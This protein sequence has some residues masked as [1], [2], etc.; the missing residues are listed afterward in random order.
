[1]G[2]DWKYGLDMSVSERNYMYV[3]TCELTMGRLLLFPI[4]DL[5]G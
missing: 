1:M 3:C 5:T 4:A 2:E